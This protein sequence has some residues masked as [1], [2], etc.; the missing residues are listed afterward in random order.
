VPSS[1]NNP[2]VS[3]CT[4]AWLGEIS[5]TGTLL[6]A[7]CRILVQT[8]L[9][10]VRDVHPGGLVFSL[11]RELDV[12]E[13]RALVAGSV[14]E[15]FYAACSVTDDLQDGDTDVYL[16]A[17][18]M[19]LRINAQVQ[20]LSLVAVRLAGLAETLDRS[21]RGALIVDPYRTLAIMLTGQRLELVRDPWNIAAYER[22]ARLSAGEQFGTYFRI[23]A[24]AANVDPGP[25]VEYGRSFGT[26]LQIVTDDETEDARLRCLPSDEVARLCRTAVDD[27]S[28]GWSG[29][30]T[31]LLNELTRGVVKRCRLLP[32]Y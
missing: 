9:D 27:L 18:P 5:E 16:G 25:W 20:L 2:A 29:S 30:A 32:E 17:V 24:A 12:D 4:R 21:V 8:V 28:R 6:D 14:C 31:T 23:A 1:L 3:R 22:V 15:M 19:P 11:S 26:L 13:E 7:E 10:K